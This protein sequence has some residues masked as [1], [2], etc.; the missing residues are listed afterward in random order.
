MIKR[1]WKNKPLRIGLGAVLGGA[2]GFAYWYF[3][4]C[5]SGQCPITS[6]PYVSTAWGGVMG[7]LLFS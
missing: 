3:V 4:G 6:S 2:A 1:L 5:N 7:L